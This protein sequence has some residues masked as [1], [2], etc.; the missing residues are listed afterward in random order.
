MCIVKLH[1][2]HT[3]PND[4]RAYAYYEW[5]NGDGTKTFWYPDGEGS[6]G[7]YAWE[8]F[9][10]D[11]K[12][13]VFGRDG[14][15]FLEPVSSATVAVD[16]VCARAQIVI[17]REVEVEALFGTPEQPQQ[18]V[19]P[20]DIVRLYCDVTLPQNVLDACLALRVTGPFDLRLQI[21]TLLLRWLEREDLV[22]RYQSWEP[23]G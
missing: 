23:L 8:G 15:P 16:F 7:C 12:P 13:N 14:N 22:T 19:F 6:E 3:Y 20:M 10:L 2:E 4:Y 5:R 18:I 9:R 17:G 1:P 21:P 11:E